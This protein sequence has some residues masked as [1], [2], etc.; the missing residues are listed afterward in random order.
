[1]TDSSSSEVSRILRAA[2]DGAPVDQA[3]LLPLVYD[4]LRAIA[5]RRMA[6]ERPGHTL[7]PTALVHEA[8]LRL[9]GDGGVGWSGKAHFYAA[10]SEA[11]RRILVDH[12]R[13]QNSQKRGG[14][15]LRLALDVVELASREDPAEILALDEAV[16]RLEEQDPRMAE[17]VK[18]R[19]FAGLQDEETAEALNVS[20]RTVCREWTMARAFLQREMGRE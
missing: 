13:A 18:L 2:A 6:T 1:M 8:Y 3:A 9:V 19:F 17:I 16:S 10:A 7:G 11:M 12:A 15:R 20:R 14:G 4:G 5:A